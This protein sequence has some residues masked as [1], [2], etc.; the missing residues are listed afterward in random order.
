MKADANPDATFVSK[1]RCVSPS[2]TAVGAKAEFQTSRGVQLMDTN[3]AAD[4]WSCSALAIWK[5]MGLAR[6]V[7]RTV[8]SQNPPTH[9]SNFG[10]NSSEVASHPSSF[11]NFGKEAH[12]KVIIEQANSMQQLMIISSVAHVSIKANRSILRPPGSQLPSVPCQLF[13][14]MDTVYSTLLRIMI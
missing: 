6:T 14:L 9:A 2:F 12:N 11:S 10:P 8:C 13:Y 7:A 3:M 5:R 4:K 1:L